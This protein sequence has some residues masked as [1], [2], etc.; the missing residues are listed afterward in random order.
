MLCCATCSG[1][2]CSAREAGLDDLQRSP[3][4]PIILWFCGCRAMN[5]HVK[6]LEKLD[7]VIKWPGHR[8]PDRTCSIVI[9]LWK[10]SPTDIIAVENHQSMPWHLC[11]CQ[12][13]AEVARSSTRHLLLRSTAVKMTCASSR[14]VKDSAFRQSLTSLPACI[15]FPVHHLLERHLLAH[16]KKS[17]TLQI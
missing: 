13:L 9:S 4:P 6:A 5:P 14:S 3:P 15:W 7:Y 8:Q 16:C 10:V 17:T 2:T 12:L 1:W 11:Y